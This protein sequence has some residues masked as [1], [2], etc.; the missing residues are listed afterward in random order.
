MDRAELQEALRQ[1]GITDFVYALPGIR[2]ATPG[3]ESYF[4]VSPRSGGFVFGAFERGVERIGYRSWAEDDVCRRCYQELVF[5]AKVRPPLNAAEEEAAKQRTEAL[6][7]DVS[8]TA[9]GAMA[10][11][12]ASSMPYPLREGVIVDQFGQESGTY[13]YPDGTPMRQRSL[14]PSVLNTTDPK[15]P[16]NY[17]RY[18]VARPFRVRAGMVAPAFEQPGGG[19]QFKAEPTLLPEAPPLL[20]ILWLLRNGYLSRVAADSADPDRAPLN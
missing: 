19:V 6:V 9:R 13:L 11:L 2:E 14:P 3:L 15:F 18:E 8:T 20:S 12:K 16:F 1:A 4:F 10:Q 5:E 17:H 7:K